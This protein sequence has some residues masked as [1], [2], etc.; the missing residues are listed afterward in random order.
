MKSSQECREK[1]RAW[2]WR[3]RVGWGGEEGST[4]RVFQGRTM[5]W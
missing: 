4:A 5:N 3:V 1:R 2:V